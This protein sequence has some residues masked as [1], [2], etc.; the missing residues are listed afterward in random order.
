MTPD[1]L[2]GL[3]SAEVR[4]DRATIRRD[5]RSGRRSLADVLAEHNACLDGVMLFTLMSWRRGWGRDALRKLGALAVREQINLAMTVG[6]AG[7]RTIDWLT[8]LDQTMGTYS[9]TKPVS[10]RYGVMPS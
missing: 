5:L 1:A 7:A 4:H 8:G 3:R 10:Q 9:A 2:V 6:A